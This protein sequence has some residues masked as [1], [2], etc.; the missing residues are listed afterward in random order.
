MDYID[1]YHTLGVAHNATQADIKRAYRK[2]ARKYHPD[3]HPDDPEAE[4]KFQQLNEANEVLGDPEKRRKYDEYGEHWKQAEQM[5]AQRRAKQRTYTGYSYDGAFTGFDPTEEAGDTHSDTGF[6]FGREHPF[7][8]FTQGSSGFSAFFEQLFGTQGRTKPQTRPGQDF[9]AELQLTLQEAATTHR[10]IVRLLDRKLRITLPA[11]IAD[12][13]R[14]RLAGKGGKGMNGAPDGDLYITIHI[15]PDPR[16]ER[17][18]D[19]LK[20]TAHITLYTALLGG[21]ITIGTLTGKVKLKV[22]P[23]T[24]NLSKVRL[25]GKGFPRYKQE[26]EAGDLIVTFQ[27]DLPKELTPKQQELFSQIRQEEEKKAPSK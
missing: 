12:G 27:V 11:G 23:L 17:L 22:R 18:G 15:T 6:G 19:D 26:G 4:K 1:Y 13:Q 3:L 20:T 7:G 16:F 25:R 10:R 21:E 5:E 24:Q 2:L 9:E 8:D 14:I